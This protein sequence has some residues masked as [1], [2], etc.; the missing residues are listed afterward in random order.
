MLQAGR[1]ESRGSISGTAKKLLLSFGYLWLAGGCIW[2]VLAIFGWLV[3]A[4]G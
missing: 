2:L 1:P 4:A 3:D